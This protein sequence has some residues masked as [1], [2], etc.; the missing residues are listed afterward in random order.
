MSTITSN[1]AGGGVWSE[2]TTWAGGV[3]PADNDAVV[4]AAG[5]TVTFDA[6]MSGYATGI[7]G[8]TITSHATTPGMLRCK[9]SDAGTYY[10]KLKTGTTIAGTN[11]A[12]KG[13]LLA[14]SDGVWGNTGALPFDRKFIIDLGATGKIDALYL[15]IALYCT[16]PSN[17]YVSTYGTKY[18]CTANA[19]TDMLTCSGA[20]GWPETTP[21]MVKSSGTLPAPL[22]ADTVYYVSAPSGADLKLA[23]VSG[24]TAIDLTDAGTGTIEVYDGHQSTSTDTMNVLSDVTGDAGWVTTDGH[25]AVVLVDAHAPDVYDQ[26]RLALTTINAA[27]LQ[28][29]A[30]IDSVQY[31]GARIYLMSRNI[32]I[33]S[34]CTTAVNIVDYGAGT[35]GGVYQ[36]EIRSTAGTGTTFYG[37]GVSGGAGHIISGTVS[38]CSS[39]VYSG[40]LHVISGCIVACSS[41]LAT[42]FFG[43]GTTVS[44]KI[45]GCNYGVVSGVGVEVSGEITGCTYAIADAVSSFGV[46]GCL[47]SGAVAGGYMGIS[48]ALQSVVSGSI[49]G[50]WYAISNSA[51]MVV[52]GTISGST[53]AGYRSALQLLGAT[54]RDNATDLVECD[55]T[56]YGATLSSATQVRSYKHAQAPRLEGRTG[57]ALQNLAGV[58]GALGFWTLG[59][60]CKSAAY[61]AGT[62]GTP[63]ISAP[64][65]L[66]HEMTFEDSDRVCWVELPVWAVAGK[67]LTVTLHGKL[68]G[69]SA[70]TT[71]PSVSICDPTQPWQ[72]VAEK[73]VESVM[74]SSTDWQTLTVSYTP[75]YGRELRVRVQGVGGTAAGVGTEKLYW[76]HVVEVGEAL[77]LAAL[78]SELTELTSTYGVAPAS[79]IGTPVA[80][81]GGSATIAGMLTK[82]AD[83][84]GGSDYD[85]TTDSLTAIR[86]RGDAGWNTATGFSTFNSASDSVTVGDYDT[87]KS[88]AEQVTGFAVPGDAMTLTTAYD[89]AKTAAQAGDAMTLTAGERTSIGTAVWATTTRTLTSLGTFLDGI[90]TAVWG[91][92]TRTLSAFGFT[93]TPDAG[94]VAKVD[95]IKAQTDNLP[96]SPAAV[97]SAMTLTAAYD[98][99]KDDVLTPLGVVDGI[100]DAILEDT[101]TTL[102][103]SIANLPTDTDVS[104]AVWD[105]VSTEYG[106]PG[107]YG[108]A[109]KALLF[110]ALAGGF[111]WSYSGFVDETG[112]ATVEIGDSYS[113]AHG[114]AGTWQVA[115]ADH[116]L[117][118][119]TA[120]SLTFKSTDASWSCTAT[121]TVD[122]YTIVCEVTALQTGAL[123]AGTYDYELEAVL[124]DGDVVSLLHNTLVVEAT[125]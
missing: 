4:I 90:P 14:N 87:G 120:T 35:H 78:Q 21:V 12:A 69:T 20:H 45:S 36:C 29:S 32:S 50:T 116:A 23:P 81:D 104:T 100:A 63:P 54:L 24:G 111:T 99:A 125:V 61:A 115:D 8:I 76:F 2:A 37:A 1:G 19:A 71:R 40:S 84:N 121:S 42:P 10:L 27:T 108:A 47:L 72:G 124:A 9:Y 17:L 89:A 56:G 31:P 70:F 16:Q 85:A 94:T 109:L 13:R 62:H 18:T 38:G 75:T 25:D 92:T 82:M 105:A 65:G 34:T 44:G 60:Y 122:G 59:G 96:A 53:R 113:I 83:D 43:T 112:V 91:A 22:V 103:A 80:L 49:R 28:L 118:L 106:G 95:G 74:S 98:H 55:A 58:S 114:R 64:N 5:D 11:L 86:D 110:A 6:D 93:P 66:V 41:A 77:T 15:D 68:T 7:A 117:D 51:G 30:N 33:R 101:G 88:P 79:A 46:R 67:P 73:L 26:Q 123:T 48:D 97:G 52:T 3:A 39:G 102:P 107:T 119:D 57:I